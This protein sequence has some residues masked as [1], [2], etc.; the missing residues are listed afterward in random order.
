M[1]DGKSR[2]VPG[3]GADLFRAMMS[4]R[5]FVSNTARMA[6]GLSA[7]PLLGACGGGDDATTTA[8]TT[9][10][11]SQ[12]PDLSGERITMVTYGDRAGE[13]LENSFAKPF[14]ELT[15]L[16]IVQDAPVD[17]AKIQAQVDSGRVMWDVVEGDLFT[18]IRYC[19]ELFEEN[20][21]VDLSGVDERFIISKC[22]APN[23]IFAAMLA[24]DESK[25]GDDPPTS[26][27]DYFDVEKYPGKRGLWTFI[28]LNPIEMALLG[29]GVAPEDLYPC[30]VDRALDKLDSIRDHIVF[31]DT[32]GQSLE[33]MVTG[34]VAMSAI[35]N[36]RG[37]FA[38]EQGATFAPVWNQ[39][40]LSWDVW[41]I[42]KGSPNKEAAEA[43]MSYMMTPEPQ[44]KSAAGLAFGP[45]AK[46]VDGLAEAS[47]LVAKWLPTAPENSENTILMDPAWWSENYDDVLA[48]Y[49]D[50]ISG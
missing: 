24:Y 42:P 45:T 10:A 29:D 26:W 6:A 8:D 31:Y 21:N 5:R 50:W 14:S 2:P 32:L 28:A 49:T 34:A 30:D 23:N 20:V 41:S 13:V 48:R 16:E 44:I 35:V 40:I 36:A 47:E 39:A 9:A 46:G 15:G 3:A 19:G 11:D 27:V 43:F 1:E 17:Y 37:L 33:Q 18:T 38:E 25:F 7:V 22:G 4:R 12:Y